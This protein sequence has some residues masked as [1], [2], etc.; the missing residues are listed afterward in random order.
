MRGNPRSRCPLKGRGETVTIPKTLTVSLAVKHY[1]WWGPD[2]LGL[3]AGIAGPVTIP[4]GD[5]PLEPP[6][7]LPVLARPALRHRPLPTVRVRPHWQRKRA[8]SGMRDADMRKRLRIRRILKW[9]GLIACVLIVVAWGVSLRWRVERYESHIHATLLGGQVYV[10]W[11]SGQK[12]ATAAGRW[13]VSWSSTSS[14]GYG[15]RWPYANYEPSPDPPYSIRQPLWQVIL[16]LWLPLLIAAIP[17]AF[18]WHRDRRCHPLG[19]CRKCGYD[20]RGNESGRCSE[21]GTAC[22]VLGGK[23]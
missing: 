17:T 19:H 3:L 10:Y 13:R 4:R 7:T 14:F 11:F 9:T 23:E 22:Q 20:L 2:L 12:Q 5:A 21:C 1:I 18:L 15:F 6:T 8:V 16:P